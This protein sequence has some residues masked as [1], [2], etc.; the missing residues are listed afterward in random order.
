MLDK[1]DY[2]SRQGIIKTAHKVTRQSNC[3]KA[4][5]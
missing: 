4:A 3:H 2:N 1:L 5:D